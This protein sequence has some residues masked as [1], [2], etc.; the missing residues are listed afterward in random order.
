MARYE[1]IRREMQEWEKVKKPDGPAGEIEILRAEIREIQAED[2]NRFREKSVEW[3]R[4]QGDKQ[5]EIPVFTGYIRYVV[6][7]D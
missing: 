2:T 1:R 3:E 5:P 6:L 4:K 7:S